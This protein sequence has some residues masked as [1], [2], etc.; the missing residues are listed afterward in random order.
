MKLSD[1]LR[2]LADTIVSKEW[3]DQPSPS[4]S[5]MGTV[6]PMQDQTKDDT[7]TDKFLPPLQLKIELLKKAS[8]VESIYDEG[9]ESED[10]R[11]E[12]LEMLQ[13][14]RKN[15]GM[16]PLALELQDEDPLDN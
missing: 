14:L 15:A 16:T 13:Q 10:D 2:N 7:P 5:G 12:Y 9:N 3:D 6:V 8:G 11:K 1:I 4:S